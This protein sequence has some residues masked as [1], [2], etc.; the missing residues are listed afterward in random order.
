MAK[1]SMWIA[2]ATILATLD[3]R[4]VKDESGKPVI[5]EPEYDQGLVAYVYK[6]TFHPPSS[7]S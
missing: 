2:M 3:I 6:S 4:P 1:E 5:P 7:A